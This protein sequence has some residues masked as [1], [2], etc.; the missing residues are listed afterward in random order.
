[1]FLAL[2]LALS[3]VA[4]RLVWLQG[5]R[6]PELRE[7]A[8]RQRV[9]EAVL[10]AVRGSILARDGEPLAL[11]V[12]RSTIVADPRQIP[13]ALLVAQRLAPILKEE[14]G[15]VL[16]RLEGDR[17]FSYVAR[18]VDDAV[19]QQV[20]SL[21]L[22]GIRLVPETVRA[23]PSGT[24]AGAVLGI[25][26]VDGQGLE[27]LEYGYDDVLRGRPG[28]VVE[29]RDPRGRPIPQAPSHL[30]PSVPGR[31]LVLSIDSRLQYEV[32]SVLEAGVSRY[33]AKGGMAMVMDPH[34]GE[35]LALANAPGFSPADFSSVPVEGRR[36]RA[37]TDVFEP[38]STNKVITM[39]AALETGAVT[40]TTRIDVPDRLWVADEEFHDAH[41]HETENWTIDDILRES[42]NIGTIKVAQAVGG[43]KLDDFLDRFG[44]GRTTG[45]DFP[46]EAEG[47]V[48]PYEDWS[49]TSYATIPVGQGIATSAVQMTLVYA[50]VANDGVRPV[51]SLVR[52]EQ[53]GSGGKVE[54][55]RPSD[56]PRRIISSETAQQLRQMLQLVVDKGTGE[57]AAVPG[58]P[59]GG[60]TGTARIPGPD[61]YSD[62]YVASFI[63]FAPADDPQVVVSVFIDQPTSTIY[64]GSTAAP[65]FSEIT[66]F[67]LRSMKVS[68]RPDHLAGSALTTPN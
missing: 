2:A 39:A 22:P 6:A 68:P 14:P 1:M 40:R 29:E 16:P 26:G 12:H 24:M 52:G 60:K 67:A 7:R 43:K 44:Y 47:I 13:D 23:Y 42:S 37:V 11:S 54:Q 59:V 65:L 3:A 62:A 61:G 32:E 63:G 36:N 8:L 5:V 25:A 41:D 20:Q 50:T 38:G 21:H 15:A 17:S 33:Q 9:T 58:Y 35:I 30:E 28:R 10:P 53:A 34:T 31:S 56:V 46:G 27:G 45:L 57:E 4:A 19:A 64:G 18:T 48:L 51:P 66:G 55:R 49:G